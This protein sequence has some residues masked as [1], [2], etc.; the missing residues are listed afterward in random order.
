MIAVA[1]PAQKFCWRAEAA[2]ILFV[3]EVVLLGKLSAHPVA[4]L[5]DCQLVLCTPIAKVHIA[6]PRA[7]TLARARMAQLALAA[8]ARANALVIFATGRAWRQCMHFGLV[9]WFC[10]AFKTQWRLGAVVA[11]AVFADRPL[12]PALAALAVF[13]TSA[14]VLAHWRIARNAGR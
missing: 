3:V 11:A 13:P 6:V 14:V 4:R 12:A 2:N 9:L 1:A 5:T 8:A 10:A 7:A